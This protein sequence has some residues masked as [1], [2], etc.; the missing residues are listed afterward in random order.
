M[1]AKASVEI[2]KERLIRCEGLGGSPRFGGNKDQHFVRC[3]HSA[4]KHGKERS[5]R[6]G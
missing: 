1:R 6:S 2:C 5:K 4:V 3:A